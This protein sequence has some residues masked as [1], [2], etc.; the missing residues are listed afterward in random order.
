MKAKEAASYKTSTGF[1][2][3]CFQTKVPLDLS[4]ETCEHIVGF[5]TKRGAMPLLASVRQYVLF[6]PHS[7]IMSPVRVKLRQCPT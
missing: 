7:N 5:L 1:G 3:D 4:T 6:F 2:T